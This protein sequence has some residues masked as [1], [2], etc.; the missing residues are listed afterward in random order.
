VLDYI[1]LFSK[2]VN[3]L[4][5][6]ELTRE[7]YKEQKKVDLAEIYISGDWKEIPDNYK[8]ISEILKNK[9][10]SYF[11]CDI[12]TL[13]KVP[14]LFERETIVKKLPLLLLPVLIL[15][16]DILLYV[17]ERKLNL[18]VKSLESQ[19]VLLSNKVSRLENEK[20]AIKN[21]L[22]L[23]DSFFE[24]KDIKN[25]LTTKRYFI[26][27]FFCELTPVLKKTNSY[28]VDFRKMKDNSFEL[29]FAT[30]CKNI[31]SPKEYKFFVQKFQNIRSIYN[32]ELINSTPLEDYNII[33]STWKVM[34]KRSAYIDF[35]GT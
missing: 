16:A 7:F 2:D 28:I 24:R 12:A 32:I 30:F 21:R 26:K 34:L 18:R 10:F 8:K 20:L 22:N 31:N 15:N 23:L 29:R 11:V 33:V 3:P 19:I 13:T 17:K 4:E 35:K 9:D 6:I 25:L 14:V 1:K 5:A 27:E